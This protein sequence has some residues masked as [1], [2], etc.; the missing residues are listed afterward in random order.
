MRSLVKPECERLTI[1]DLFV[2]L[3]PFLID[4]DKVP[5]KNQQ[6]SNLL[7]STKNSVAFLSE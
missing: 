5:Y 6:N 2:D 4:I 7:K 1:I 3:I